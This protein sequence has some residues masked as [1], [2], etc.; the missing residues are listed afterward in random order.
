MVLFAEIFVRVGKW[1][2]TVLRYVEFPNYVESEN[3]T[4]QIPKY[5]N[6]YAIL[7]SICNISNKD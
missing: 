2:K 4:Q 5:A 7:I 1:R 3:L 6:Q